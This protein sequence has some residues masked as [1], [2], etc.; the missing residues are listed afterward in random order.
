MT[1]A[2]HPDFIREAVLERWET[3]RWTWQGFG[4]VRMYLDPA[5]RY[6]LNIWDERSKVPRVSLIHDH[7]WS[8]KSAI[9]CGEIK[10]QR[11]VFRDDP[12]VLEAF[13]HNYK[14][15]KTGEEL[16]EVHDVR[17]CLLRPREPETYRR[18]QTYEQL[19]DEV[20]ETH[21]QI[22]TVTVNERT[23]P[24]QEYSARVFWH[25]N[26]PHWVSAT[27]RPAAEF[28]VK[29]AVARALELWLQ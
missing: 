22:G 24:T 15:I 19:L 3:H 5:K 8:F 10:N 21:A 18:G 25:R 12:R 17:H 20:H 6:R 1:Y 7:P 27:P 13:T 28:E 9:Y 23:A 29:R 26:E 2:H 4:M 14:R 11:Y 16:S